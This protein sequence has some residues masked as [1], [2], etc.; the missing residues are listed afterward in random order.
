MSESTSAPDPLPEDPVSAILNGIKYLRQPAPPS[1]MA[2][3]VAHL[4]QRRHNLPDVVIVD[5][6]ALAQQL[7]GQP[8]RKIPC[9]ELRKALGINTQDCLG[10]RLRRVRR[11][12]LIECYAV[13]RGD[14]GY[15]FLRIGPVLL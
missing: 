2:D 4:L 5:C 6:L 3:M 7:L 12:G 1:P 11:A 14:P 9:D 10:N 15:Q 13:R 8:P